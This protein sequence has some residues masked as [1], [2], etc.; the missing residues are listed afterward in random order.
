MQ[1][2][3]ALVASL[4]V[5]SAVGAMSQELDPGETLQGRSLAAQRE[6]A[7]QAHRRASE[8]AAAE[9]RSADA[10]RQAKAGEGAAASAAKAAPDSQQAQGKTRSKVRWD[11]TRWH[12]AHKPVAG[13]QG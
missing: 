5:V 9:A 1:V 7:E 11:L 6:Q 8:S 3:Q 12:L 10:A 2:R 4:L 13:E